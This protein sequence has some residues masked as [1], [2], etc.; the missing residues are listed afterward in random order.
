MEVGAFACQTINVGRLD[1]GVPV[2]AQ[3]T[4]APVIGKD[5]QDIGLFRS[6][7][8]HKTGGERQ[9]REG[10][11]NETRA[12]FAKGHSL[13]LDDRYGKHHAGTRSILYRSPFS[14]GREVVEHLTG[15]SV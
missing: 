6:I 15:F 7:R 1:V 3:V 5:E 8:G 13:S 11:N 12:R 10:P 2:T 9:K 4:P 14:E